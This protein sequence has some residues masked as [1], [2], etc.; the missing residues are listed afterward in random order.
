MRLNICIL[1]VNKLFRK[2]QIYRHIYS[3]FHK[4][5]TSELEGICSRGEL[6]AGSA[7]LGMNGIL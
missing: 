7:L 5:A 1:L 3:Q 2:L 6:Y 4:M